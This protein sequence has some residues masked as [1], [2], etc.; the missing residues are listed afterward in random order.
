MA[1]TTLT[2]RA[3][4]LVRVVDVP[5]ATGGADMGGGDPDRGIDIEPWFEIVKKLGAGGNVAVRRGDLG[6]L[7]VGE[8]T[9]G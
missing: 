4:G 8:A 7:D 6:D 2:G 3:E 1:W 9:C 5:L